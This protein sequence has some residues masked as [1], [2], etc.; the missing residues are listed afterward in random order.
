MT[1]DDNAT[2]TLW[3]KEHLA[4]ISLLGAT[5]AFTFDVGCFSAIGINF[6]TLFSLS[7]HLVFAIQ[8]LPIALL[9]LFALS[10]LAVVMGAKPWPPPRD[11]KNVSKGRR[12][13]AFIIVCL[14]FLGLLSYLVLALYNNPIMLIIAMVLAVLGFGLLVLKPVYKPLFTAFMA[15]F[16]ANWVAFIF[17]YQLGTSYLSKDDISKGLMSTGFNVV[18]F[19]DGASIKGRIMRSGDRGVLLYDPASDRVLFE[20]WD[21]IHSIEANPPGPVRRGQ[22]ELH[23]PQQ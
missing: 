4:Y 5:V 14:L 6:F 13:A 11:I 18:E 8:A 22:L 16:V 1:E 19:K 15:I 20:L 17:G 7:E 21:T 3:D 9:M 2:S 23:V 10:A 12:I